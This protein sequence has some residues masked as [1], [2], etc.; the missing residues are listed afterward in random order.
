MTFCIKFYFWHPQ[1][2]LH[3]QFSTMFLANF[4]CVQHLLE[5]QDGFAII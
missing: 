5:W 2:H 4:I 1:D 3:L